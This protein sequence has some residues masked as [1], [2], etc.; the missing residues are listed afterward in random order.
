MKYGEEKTLKCKD[1]NERNEWRIEKNHVNMISQT[2]TKE[3][4][5]YEMSSKGFKTI[6]LKK[7]NE[8]QECMDFDKIK[9]TMNELKKI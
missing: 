7:F 5:I 6:L 9:K 2:D 4:Y 3:K 1:T 8:L